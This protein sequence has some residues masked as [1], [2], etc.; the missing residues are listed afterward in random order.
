M[1]LMCVQVVQ[2]CM[3]AIK[4]PPN[5]YGDDSS[6]RAHPS[7]RLMWAEAN[8]TPQKF[9]CMLE[10]FEPA[11]GLMLRA[12]TGRHFNKL[13]PSEESSNH[14]YACLCCLYI[15]ASCCEWR[16]A[17]VR[18]LKCTRGLVRCGSLFLFTRSLALAESR[19]A[20]C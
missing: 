15:L 20:C 4:Q 18:C 12:L 17:K 19:S 7:L 14:S 8:P 10:S 11:A 5:H 13:R 1:A 3:E 2:L 16:L 6:T 9:V